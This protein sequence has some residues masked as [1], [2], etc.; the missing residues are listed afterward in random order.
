MRMQIERDLPE[1]LPGRCSVCRQILLL[2]AR[3][4]ENSLRHDHI[5]C[6]EDILNSLSLL[7]GAEKAQCGFG[8][9]GVNSWNMRQHGNQVEVSAIMIEPDDLRRSLIFPQPVFSRKFIVVCP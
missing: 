5:E 6:V 8:R 2:D 4:K 9:S 3:T 1:P 7:L